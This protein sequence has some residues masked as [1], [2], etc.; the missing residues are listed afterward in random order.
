MEACGSY[1]R[2]KADSGDIDLLVTHPDNALGAGSIIR[3]LVAALTERGLATHALTHSEE[4]ADKWRGLCRLSPQLPHRRLDLQI[5]PRA[6]RP[7]ALLYFTGSAHF[8]RAMRER[9]AR[10]GLSLSQHGL[11][12]RPAPGS[13]KDMYKMAGAAPVPCASEEDVFRALEMEY[14]PPSQRDL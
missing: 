9:A 5:V 12:V 6:A 3:R 1:R 13:P 11:V 4:G 2:G 7:F 10:R 14:V 8:N